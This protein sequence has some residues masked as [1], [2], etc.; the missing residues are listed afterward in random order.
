MRPETIL[1][2]IVFQVVAS[3]FLLRAFCFTDKFAAW[4]ENVID[5]SLDLDT[6]SYT[7]IIIIVVILNVNYSATFF[8]CFTSVYLHVIFMTNGFNSLCYTDEVC[9]EL[10]YGWRGEG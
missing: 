8:V 3:R 2:F 4:T 1:N 10:D 7:Y 5:V 6:C 9:I